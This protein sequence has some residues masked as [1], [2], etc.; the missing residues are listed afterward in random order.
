[1][2]IWILR[3][4]PEEKKWLR[5]HPPQ[6]SV[7]RAKEAPAAAAAPLEAVAHAAATGDIDGM[8]QYAAHHNDILR[9][10]DS[11]GW[12]PIHEAVRAGHVEAVELLVK[13]GAKVDARTGPTGKGGSP[14]NLALEYLYPEH[15]VA[16][17]LASLGASDIEPEL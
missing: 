9:Q 3:G 4:S 17:Y 12:Q 1:M 10:K 5:E 16:R 8:T 2:P 15:P 11:N 14:L 7:R 13:N 6:R